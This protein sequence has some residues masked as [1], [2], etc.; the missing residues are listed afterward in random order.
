MTSTRWSDRPFSVSP[1]DTARVVQAV[2]VDRVQDGFAIEGPA[3]L[4]RGLGPHL[5]G[6]LDRVIRGVWREDNPRVPTH[7]LII[8][9]LARQDVKGRVGNVT[10]VEGGQ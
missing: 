10:G 6:G 2:E 5:L 3:D 7:S 9:R 1:D 4:H 8:E